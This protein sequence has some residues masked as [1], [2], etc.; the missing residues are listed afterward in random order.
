MVVVM[1]HKKIENF[2]IILAVIGFHL[3]VASFAIKFVV[4]TWRAWT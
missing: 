4:M 3:I 2:T 1:M